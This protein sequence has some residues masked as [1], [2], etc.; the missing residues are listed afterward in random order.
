MNKISIAKSIC[1]GFMTAFTSL[2]L[3]SFIYSVRLLVY[4]FRHFITDWTPKPADHITFMYSWFWSAPIV[5]AIVLTTFSPIGDIIASLFFSIR[6]QSQRENEKIAPA[7][8]RVKTLYRE[9]FFK[10]LDMDVY[11]MDMPIINGLALGQRT[12][13]L[14]TGLLKTANDEQIAAVLAHEAGHLHYRDGFYNLALLAATIPMIVLYGIW[15]IFFGDDEDKPKSSSSSS[16]IS[17]GFVIP[18]ILIVCCM[19]PFIGY[20][21]LSIPVG[22][23]MSSVEFFTEWPIEYRA[24]KFAVELGLGPALIEL[25]EHSEDEDIRNTTGFLSKYLY[26]H[27]PTALRIDRIERDLMAEGQQMVSPHAE[28]LRQAA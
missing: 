24:D 22:W 9:K 20:C 14:S 15:G 26:S 10:E 3:A 21:L 23:L 8:E 6:I 11:V 16:E 12:A 25:L 28:E 13:A 18:V 27:P 19:I 17:A 2:F 1:L 7:L 5:L 4:A